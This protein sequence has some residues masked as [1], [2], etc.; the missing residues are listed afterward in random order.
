[1]DNNTIEK[2][3]LSY[4]LQALLVYRLLIAFK[5]NVSKKEIL[6]YYKKYQVYLKNNSWNNGIRSVKLNFYKRK[7]FIKIRELI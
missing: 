4:R 3:L 5:L 2:A 7:F 1:M 6:N